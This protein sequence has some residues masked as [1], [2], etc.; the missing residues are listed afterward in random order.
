LYAKNISYPDLNVLEKSLVKVVSE[1]DEFVEIKEKI[2]VALTQGEKNIRTANNSILLAKSKEAWARLGVPGSRIIPVYTQSEL[3][4]SSTTKWYPE[5]KD[6]NMDFLKR[7]VSE[8][9]VESRYKFTEKRLKGLRNKIDEF[10]SVLKSK[11]K[12]DFDID[13]DKTNGDFDENEGD[14]KLHRDEVNM[15]GKPM[16]EEIQRKKN[17]RNKFKEIIRILRTF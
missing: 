16:N 1:S 17:I 8:C 14:E 7:T 10:V 2:I 9:V 6:T 5:I 15:D 13:F 3:E 4:K 11:I 12:E